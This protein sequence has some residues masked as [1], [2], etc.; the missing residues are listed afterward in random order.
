MQVNDQP[1]LVKAGNN[2]VPRK[3]EKIGVDFL[4]GSFAG[5]SST[6]CGHPLEYKFLQKLFLRIVV[7]LK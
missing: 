6:L 3:F 2:K 1:A 7:L 4:A 5:F